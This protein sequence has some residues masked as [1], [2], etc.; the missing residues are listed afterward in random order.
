MTTKGVTED[1]T[2][3]TGPYSRLRSMVFR[4]PGLPHPELAVLP[5]GIPLTAGDSRYMT[6]K[7]LQ[8]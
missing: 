5:H 1:L 4:I 2:L 6:S 7:G 8:S 3:G